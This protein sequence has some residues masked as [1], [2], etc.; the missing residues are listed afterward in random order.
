MQAYLVLELLDEAI[1]KA[2]ANVL[3]IRA[4]VTGAGI[5]YKVCSLNG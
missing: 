3:T 2:V 5:I 1:G 4:N